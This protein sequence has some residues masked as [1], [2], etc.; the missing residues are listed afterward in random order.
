MGYSVL[1]IR[2]DEDGALA[3]STEFCRLVVELDCLLETTGGG[4]SSNNGISER[5]NYTRADMMR[6][7]LSVMHI[8]F[9]KYL[10]KDVDINSYWCFA[11]VMAG[12]VQRRIYNRMHDEIPFYLV[13]KQRPSLRECV[14]PGSIMTIIDP[15]K[16]NL[17]LKKL[18]GM[19]FNI[20]HKS[21]KISRDTSLNY[22]VKFVKV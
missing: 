15:N 16:N 8:L 6:S 22:I 12:F 5:S 13:H 1:F 21:W 2:V 14:I 3:K 10:P 4:N 9:G 20:L 17:T 7:Q 11:Y 19:Q 18:D